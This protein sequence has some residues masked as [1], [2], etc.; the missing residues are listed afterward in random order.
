ML[1]NGL[2]FTDRSFYN[3]KSLSWFL[4]GSQPLS[5]RIQTYKAD[6]NRHTTHTLIHLFICLQI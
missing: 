3:K 5:I 1:I 6:M 2:H 4:I